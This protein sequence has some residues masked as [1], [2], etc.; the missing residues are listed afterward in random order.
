MNYHGSGNKSRFLNGIII[1]TLQSRWRNVQGQR[2]I[3]TY[4]LDGLAPVNRLTFKECRYSQRFFL[5]QSDMETA[6]AAIMQS[7]IG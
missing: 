1:R 3:G 6:I 7:A 4:F 5:N 2:S